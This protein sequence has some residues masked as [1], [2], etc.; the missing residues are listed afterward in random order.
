MINLVELKNIAD[1][2]K[3][4]GKPVKLVGKPTAADVRNA[5]SRLALMERFEKLVY[6]ATPA[7]RRDLLATIKDMLEGAK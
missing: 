2:L 3:A 5:K 7:E 6:D 4:L 1:G